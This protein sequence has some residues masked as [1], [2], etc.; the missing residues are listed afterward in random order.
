MEENKVY[1]VEDRFKNMTA[2]EKLNLS[3][4]LYHS[5]WELKKAALAHFNPGITEE[6]LEKKVKEIFFYARS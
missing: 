2:E 4:R 3:L 1:R 6:E 5:A